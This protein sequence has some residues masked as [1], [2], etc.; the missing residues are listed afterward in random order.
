[1]KS[2]ILARPAPTLDPTDTD[3]VKLVN[4]Q[5]EHI[6][7]A[8]HLVLEARDVRARADADLDAA[9]RARDRAIWLYEALVGDGEAE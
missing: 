4:A 3:G 1:M 5:R 2:T 6:L 7:K 9:I 8:E